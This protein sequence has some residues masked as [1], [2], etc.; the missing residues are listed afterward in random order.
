MKPKSPT[1]NEDGLLEYIED[2]I[3]SSRLIAQI[4]ES[5]KSLEELNT[6]RAQQLN[7]V[8]A[9]EKARDSLLSSKN[10]A[11]QCLLIEGEIHDN[12]AILYQLQILANQI[13]MDNINEKAKPIEEKLQDLRD[14]MKEK[15]DK[16]KVLED[17]YETKRK[18]HTVSIIKLNNNYNSIIFIFLLLKENCKRT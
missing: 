3:G 18:E 11:E 17:D 6:E 1:P 7:R 2:I 8:K 16:L 9:S 13:K 12:N 4:E 15:T 5:V 10:E 14:S